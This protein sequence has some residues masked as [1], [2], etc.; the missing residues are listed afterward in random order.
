MSD[1]GAPNGSL[2]ALL[3]VL[4]AAALA[5]FLV[6]LLQFM[7]MLL[8]KQW[9]AVAVFVAL[10]SV[11]GGLGD[12]HPLLSLP[13]NLLV[14]GMLAFL[15]LRF[16]LLAAVSALTFLSYAE[17]ITTLDVSSWSSGPTLFALGGMLVLIFYGFITSLG[18]RP[19]FGAGLLEES[20]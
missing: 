7:R 11:P 14:G 18:G 19:L 16:G 8:R 1:N 12:D 6:F 5:M 20:S 13:F 15:L 9:L 4:L 17:M 10:I 3:G 2:G